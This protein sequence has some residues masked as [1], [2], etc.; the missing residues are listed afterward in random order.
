MKNYSKRLY[1]NNYY[2]K[3]DKHDKDKCF[4]V[5]NKTE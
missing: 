3:K 5:K 2:I 1:Q 4:I